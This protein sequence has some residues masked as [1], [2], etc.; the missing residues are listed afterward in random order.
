MSFVMWR[1]VQSSWK[2][3][4]GFIEKCCCMSHCSR[5]SPHALLQLSWSETHA[6]VCG[7]VVAVALPL[8][9]PVRGVWRL[10]PC[11]ERSLVH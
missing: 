9:E 8:G 1:A 4:S 3:R 7:Q 11:D 5:D 10:V 6:G 2:A